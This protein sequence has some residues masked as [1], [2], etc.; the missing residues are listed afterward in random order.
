LRPARAAHAGQ[1]SI[2]EAQ[3]IQV[4]PLALGD[5]VVPLSLA[6]EDPSGDPAGL[7]Y[8]DGRLDERHGKDVRVLANDPP[9]AEALKVLNPGGYANYTRLNPLPGNT[10]SA[11]RFVRANFYL[12]FLRPVVP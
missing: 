3:R 11:D 9:S 12:G 6:V 7:Q 5:L 4:T 10:N 8:I 2:A 1:P